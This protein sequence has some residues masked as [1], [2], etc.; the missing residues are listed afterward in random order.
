MSCTIEIYDIVKYRTD[1]CVFVHT[2]LGYMQAADGYEGLF[3][4]LCWQYQRFGQGKRK[5]RYSSWLRDGP[6]ECAL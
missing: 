2:N 1:R 3:A 5:A 4:A 6:P